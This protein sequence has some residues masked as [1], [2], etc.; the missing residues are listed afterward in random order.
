[1]KK[2]KALF[3]FSGGLDSI[4]GVKILEKQGIG[5]KGLTF[6]SYFFDARQAKKAG[7]ELGIRLKVVDF[8][9]EHFKIV[10]SPRYGYGQ[11]MNPCIDC[12]LL[13]L[14]IAKKIMKEKG[15]DFVATG[16][17][18]GERPMSQNKKALLLLEKESSLSGYLLRPLS[19]RL[20]AETIPEQKGLVRKE[21]LLDISGRSR[22]RQIELAKKFKIKEYPTP[23]GGCLLTDLEFGKRLRELLKRCPKCEESD[24]YLLRYG[25]HFWKE[26]VRIIVGRNKTENRI[27]KKLTEKRDILVEM[28]NYSGPVTLLRSYLRNY[29]RKQV[30][31]EIIN[32]AQELTR[33]FSTKSRDKKDVIFKVIEVK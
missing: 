18:L 13:M 14:K 27:I 5:I 16:E 4:I 23:A 24:L 11:S 6:K 8:S 29:Q 12:R 21:E 19:A 25:R 10:K 32:F 1:M 7:K 22:K 9:K 3:L 17:V 33:H 2:A 26:G 20:L 30:P 31:S 15:F 28:R